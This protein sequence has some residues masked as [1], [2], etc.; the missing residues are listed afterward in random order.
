MVKSRF[1]EPVIMKTPPE[2]GHL[3]WKHYIL[4][5]TVPILVG[6]TG[7]SAYWKVQRKAEPVQPPR[8]TRCYQCD[9]Y[10]NV[11]PSANAGNNKKKVALEG[12]PVFGGRTVVS[13]GDQIAG[14]LTQLQV[15]NLCT[16]KVNATKMRAL[17]HSQKYGTC[18][19]IH[20]DGC[21]KLVTK[22]YRVKPQ[23]GRPV[24]TAIVVSRECAMIPKGMGIGCFN[25]IGGAGLYHTMCYCRGDFC[26]SSLCLKRCHF[27]FLCIFVFIVFTSRQETYGI[28]PKVFGQFHTPDDADCMEDDTDLPPDAKNQEPMEGNRITALQLPFKVQEITC[29]DKPARK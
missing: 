12:V 20:Y 24:I 8:I 29:G 26:N 5:T 16:E 17:I 27:I 22:N 1:C 11:A 23:L 7:I 19:N 4:F 10:A 3:S 21:V 6:V 13:S 9:N 15:S 2:S 14:G 28:R 25:S 18:P